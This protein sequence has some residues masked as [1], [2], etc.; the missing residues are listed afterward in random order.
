[1][2]YFW[3]VFLNIFWAI[4][5]LLPSYSMTFDYPGYWFGTWNVRINSRKYY[6]FNKKRTYNNE[7]PLIVLW[8]YKNE[9]YRSDKSFGR[10]CVNLCLKKSEEAIQVSVVSADFPPTQIYTAKNARYHQNRY[11][12]TSLQ[13]III[14]F[15]NISSID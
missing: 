9:K 6:H 11:I 10:S 14:G 8:V 5:S 1:M 15:K 4:N 12:G 3:N 2:F 13:N 7:T